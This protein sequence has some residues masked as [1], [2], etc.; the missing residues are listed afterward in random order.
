MTDTT[1]TESSR[2]KPLRDRGRMP[3]LRHNE[4][5]QVPGGRVGKVLSVWRTRDADWQYLVQYVNEN[6][7]VLSD[8]FPLVDLTAL[9]GA[10]AASEA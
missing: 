10:D 4:A 7:S 9:D 6:G 2:K 3:R 5:V 8:W 1:A